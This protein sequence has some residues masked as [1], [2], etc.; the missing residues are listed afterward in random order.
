MKPMQ[1]VKTVFLKAP[2]EHVWRFLTEADKLALWFHVGEADLKNGGDYA[3]LTN[4]YGKEG[5]KLITGRILEMDPPKK[6]VQT[7]THQWLNGVETLCVWE[8]E[9]FDGGTALTL[10]HSGWEKVGE[11]AFGMTANHDAGWDEHFVR[12]RRVTN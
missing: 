7:F 8:L 4:T 12:L 3:L 5:E 2:R 10:T 11:G 9:E 6:L 1:L